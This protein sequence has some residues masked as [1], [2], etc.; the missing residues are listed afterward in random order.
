M[1]WIFGSFLVTPCAL[2]SC[3]AVMS[4]QEYDSTSGHTGTTGVLPEGDHVK[5][6]QK[7]RFGD[8]PGTRSRSEA[9]LTSLQEGLSVGTP[10]LPEEDIGRSPFSEYMSLHLSL[11]KQLTVDPFRE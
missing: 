3:H 1:T 4:K 11:N 8:E 7:Q 2:T 5:F 6:R 10:W 9:S